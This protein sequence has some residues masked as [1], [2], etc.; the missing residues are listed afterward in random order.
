V[1]SLTFAARPSR[2]ARDLMLALAVMAGA[3]TVSIDARAQ[4]QPAAEARIVDFDIPAGDLSVAIDRFAEQSGWQVVSDQPLLKEI[5]VTAMRGRFTPVAALTRLLQGSGLSY[6]Q[7]GEGTVVLRRSPTAARPAGAA[8]ARPQSRPEPEARTMPEVLVQGSR[9]LNMDIRRTEND[10]QPYIV[11]EREQI[12]RSMSIDLEDFLKTRLPMNTVRTSNNQSPTTL[13]NQSQINL[14]GLGTAQ[15]LV[16][17]DGRRVPGGFTGG[18]LAQADINGVPLAA[19]ERIEVLPS[20][21]SGIYGGGATG[22][23][24]N[25]ILRRDYSGGDVKLTYENSF[26]SDVARRQIDARTG[27]TLGEKTSVMVAASYSDGNPLLNGE[28]DLFARSRAL[29]L[30]NNPGMFESAAIPPLG[31]TS[32]IRSADGS[33]LV[34]KDGRALGSAITHVPVGYTGTASDGGAA[35]LANAG[36]YNLDLADAQSSSGALASMFNN[37][38]KVSITATLRHEFSDRVEGFLDVSR[39]DNK[40]YM[41]YAAFPTYFTLAASAPNNPFTSAVMVTMPDKNLRG[42]FITESNTHQAT[43]GLIVRLAHDWVGGLDYTLGK[44]EQFYSTPLTMVLPSGTAM[45]SSGALDALRDT[46]LYPVDMSPYL[47]A[48]PGEIAGPTKNSFRDV[49]LRFAGPLLQLPAGPLTLSTLLEHRESDVADSYRTAT[50]YGVTT[51]RL[52]PSR[53]QSVASAYVESRVPL[54]SERNARAGVQELDMQVSARHDRYT[55]R[56][57]TSNIVDGSNTPIQRVT[58][59]VSSTDYTLGLRYVPVASVTLRASYGTGFQPPSISDLIP[60]LATGLTTGSYVILDPK[61]GNTSPSLFDVLTDGNPDLQPEKSESLSAGIIFQPQGVPGLR[62]SLDYTRIEKTG[63]IARMQ[64][65][66]VVDNEAYFP[67]RVVRGAPLPGDPAG[68]AGPITLIDTTLAN[69]SAAKIGAYDLQLDYA[70]EFAIGTFS[71]FAAVTHQQ[72]LKRRFA[73]NSPEVQT[74]GFT[75]GPLEWRGN[76]GLT[77]SRGPLSAGWTATHFDS[78]YVYAGSASAAT[79][80]AAVRN[81][82]DAV[83]PSQTYHDVFAGYR[84]PSNYESARLWDNVEIT[85]G[86]RN[87]F[88]KLPPTIAA[89]EWYTSGTYS[90][91]G[92]PRLRTY[93]VS[94]R[95]GF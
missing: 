36:R 89:N 10:P 92:D 83:V 24:I 53:S 55:T 66:E 32:N 90:T 74:A 25:I 58:N 95:K 31:Y 14:R 42:V 46:N 48:N 49:M 41:D 43:G 40:G 1:E 77:W 3:A 93:S 47:D 18:G 15:T 29:L 50:V 8:S 34:L 33:P 20:T 87:V 94:I 59:T 7:V 19:I 37:P 64:P 17:I 69:V 28:R 72:D 79:R 78:Y 73:P 13:G 44:A 84:F 39:L 54:V 45:L 2:L 68:W 4:A 85:V 75:G 61:R 21:A 86:I 6:E 80:A 57:A 60:R 88:N 22:G 23:V 52:F 12:E 35:L 56:A 62:I 70:R 67:G 76:L 63:E 30:A 5:K 11:F 65:Q 27:F 81:Q 71:A 26:E 82:G 91:Y 51:R 16:L 9:S 38:R